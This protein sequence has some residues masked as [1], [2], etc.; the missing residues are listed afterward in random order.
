MDIRIAG[1]AGG[2]PNAR[3][4]LARAPDL[5]EH[6]AQIPPSTTQTWRSNGKSRRAMRADSTNACI[7]GSSDRAR[8]E[9]PS[10]E[11]ER[12][13]M[14]VAQGLYAPE[15][16]LTRSTSVPSRSAICKRADEISSPSSAS[17]SAALIMRRPD[18]EAESRL[19]F[20][21]VAKRKG[22]ATCSK[23]GASL[24]SWPLTPV[25]EVALSR[26]QTRIGRL[27]TRSASK[28]FDLGAKIG[29]KLAASV[30]SAS[31]NAGPPA[32]AKPSPATRLLEAWLVTLLR[33]L[34]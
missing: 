22:L 9:A 34:K 16:A 3:P 12:A 30:S 27:A 15:H 23:S 21:I 28:A 5:G 2:S 13:N 1:F 18:R 32:L 6:V 33:A 10:T 19:S 7:A 4:G 14:L 24:A 11:S 29:G 25:Q 31:P 26:R 20:K 17:I 8:A